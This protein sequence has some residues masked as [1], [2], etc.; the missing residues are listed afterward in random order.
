VEACLYGPEEA[1]VPAT[2]TDLLNGSYT[3]TFTVKR[4]GTWTLKP[5]VP[6]PR[7]PF[8]ALAV[9][10]RMQYKLLTSRPMDHRITSNVARPDAC[11]SLSINVSAL[12]L[13]SRCQ[14][15]I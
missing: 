5:R 9:L 4:Q 1:V 15:F 12:S 14:Y 3:L 6:R 8:I 2:V 10:L 11:L 13:M 7:C